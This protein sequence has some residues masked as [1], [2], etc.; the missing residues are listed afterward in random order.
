LLDSLLQEKI[1]RI[2]NIDC[3]GCIIIVIR[4]YRRWVLV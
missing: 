2:N 4:V 3:L 1:T